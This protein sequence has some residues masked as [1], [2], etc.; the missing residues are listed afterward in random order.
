MNH[1]LKD[2]D[3]IKAMNTRIM[4]QIMDVEL[5]VIIVYKMLV[6]HERAY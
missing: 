1:D 3:V 4:I 5:L 2:H 6:E